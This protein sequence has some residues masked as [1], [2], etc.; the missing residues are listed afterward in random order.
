[1][2]DDVNKVEH[3]IVEGSPNDICVADISEFRGASFLL[4]AKTSIDS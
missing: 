3:T 1:M 4:S 2:E